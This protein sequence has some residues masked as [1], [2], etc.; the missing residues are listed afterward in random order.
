MYVKQYY[1]GFI[2]FYN[3]DW[4]L[5]AASIEGLLFGFIRPLF[6]WPVHAAGHCDR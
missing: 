5:V 1:S 2:N 3:T 4:Q 6:L